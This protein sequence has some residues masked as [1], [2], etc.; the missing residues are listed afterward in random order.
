MKA[1]IVGIPRNV[2]VASG[3]LLGLVSYCLAAP[4]RRLV[5]RNLHFCYPD[6]SA[7]Q[8][9]DLSKRVFMNFGITFVE[10]CQSAFMSKEQISKTY[11]MVGEEHILNALK[12]NEGV[13]I[14]SA[15]MGNWEVAQHFSKYI[16]KPLFG[17]AAR[18]RHGPADFVLNRL[19]NR[20]GTEIIDKRGALPK[21]TETIRSGGIV[22]FMI[23]QSRRK[24][25]VEVTFFNRKATATP[26]AA[27]LALRC[28]CPVVP[29]ISVR[30]P[31]GKLA[32]QVKPPVE[33][34]KTG[35]VSR[36][37]QVNTQRMMNVVE[38]TVR[39]YPDQW[40]WLLKPWKVAYPNLYSEWDKRKRKRKSKKKR[41]T[42]SPISH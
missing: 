29:A 26:A 8:V 23:D 36:D 34:A 11:R 12:D 21:M 9:R 41:R 2:I 18:T 35:N 42:A 17:V 38:E 4:H 40:F 37:V 22:A 39:A 3:K 7:K 5:R 20:F 15:H 28:K 32:I 16:G 27:L 31:D 1:G 33:M 10:M 13:I 30:G 14:V 25:G 19:R 24:K 6:W